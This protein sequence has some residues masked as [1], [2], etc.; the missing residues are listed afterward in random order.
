MTT[1]SGVA[2][3]DTLRTCESY[4]ATVTAINCAAQVVS[5]PFAIGVQEP[6]TFQATILFNN[7]QQCTPWISSNVGDK[8]AS[9]KSTIISV[10]SLDCGH[11]SVTC[12]VN[13]SSF[14]CG[15]NQTT[16]NYQ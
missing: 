11:T 2:N 3:F 6:L 16:V 4:W 5:Q 13:N 9:I 8:L 1:A 7:G 12:T 15:S 10:L 14:T